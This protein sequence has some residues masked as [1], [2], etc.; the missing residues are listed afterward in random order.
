MSIMN[1]MYN[2]VSGLTAE[3]D[4]LGVIGNNV[5]NA[6]TVGFKES[7]AIFENVLGSAVGAQDQVG[8]GVTMASTQQI[9]AEG[10]MLSTGQPTDVALSGDGFFVVAGSVGGV[11]G[12]FYTRA[13]QTSLSSNGTLVNPDGLAFQGYQ[14]NPDGTFSSAVGPIQVSTAA[15]P[16]KETS[17]LDVTANLDSTSTPP[18]GAWNAQNPS[19]TSNFSTS[20]QVYDSLGT[21]HTVNVYMQ[22]TGPN[23]WT[24]HVL[25]NGSEVQGGTAGQNSEIATGTLTFSST[26]ALATST[27]TTGGTV[28]FDGAAAQ[29]LAFNFGTPTA[30]G[31][32]GLSGSTQFGSPSN[33]SAQSQDGYTS[34]ALSSVQIDSSGVVSG[35]YSNGQTIAVGQMAIAKFQ[36]NNGLAQAGQNVWVATSTSGVAALGNAGVG[37]RGSLATGSLENSN[38]DIATEFVDMIAHQSGFQADSKTVTT[39]D[40]ML[41]ELMQMKQ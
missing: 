41:Q 8:S 6:N 29:K 28:T 21:A 12:D 39:A 1:A 40:D 13:G 3:S 25:A 17:T 15:L 27:L 5:S 7:R 37:G 26:G 9:F 30:S 36:S 31:G 20:M 22:N 2:G 38:V 19:T 18:T 34:G 32:T 35:V 4:A 24:Y 16:P 14:A 11:T 23:A 10:S 33:I